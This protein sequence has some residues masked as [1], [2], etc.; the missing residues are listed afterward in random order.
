MSK[1]TETRESLTIN[2]RTLADLSNP[3]TSKDQLEFTPLT[4]AQGCNTCRN[5][6][7]Y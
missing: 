6:N 2:K 4:C 7:C 1:T 5:C 3:L